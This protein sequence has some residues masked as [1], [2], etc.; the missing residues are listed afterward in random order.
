MLG[1][2]AYAMLLFGSLQ[3]C[4]FIL[5]EV[6]FLSQDM[7]QK[8]A[9]ELLCFSLG[10][11]ST[12]SNYITKCHA[13]HS[14]SWWLQ[15]SIY[16]DD[17]LHFVMSNTFIRIITGWSG[18]KNIH[19][20]LGCQPH[21]PQFFAKFTDTSKQGWEKPVFFQKKST[22]LFFEKSCFFFFFLKPKCC[23]SVHSQSG[24]AWQASA[25]QTEKS[26]SHTTSAVPV[27]FMCMPN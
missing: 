11:R 18:Q 27:K 7:E 23:W 21:L 20:L 3:I 25:Q 13:F 12:L 24:K 6:F 10:S 8:H 1:D 2:E 19:W 16:K 14:K 5:W 9:I 26:H 22:Y 15:S 17:D 4:M